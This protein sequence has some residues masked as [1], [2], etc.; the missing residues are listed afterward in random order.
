[1]K[2]IINAVGWECPK[3]VIE[4]KR[5]LDTMREGTVTTIVD[6]QVA[7]NNLINLASS[8]GYEVSHNE[9]NGLIHVSVTKT[10]D[11]DDLMKGAGDLVIVIAT[12]CFGEGPKELGENLMKSYL[13]AQT[14][15]SP[16]PKTIIFNNS[17][18]FLT[19]EGS[20]VEDSLKALEADGVEILICGA[21]LNFYGLTDKLIVGSVTNMY[22]IVEIMNNAGNTIKL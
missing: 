1:M 21:C 3:P 16:K 18:V 13:Y 15:V 7:F 12:N 17:G 19:T 22:T 5:M 11:A 6:D 8:L 14:E 20:P 4:T 9:E 2:Q 10:K